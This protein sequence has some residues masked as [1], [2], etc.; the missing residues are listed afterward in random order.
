M[1]EEIEALARQKDF[2]ALSASERA[3]VLEAMPAEEYDRLHVLLQAVR[4]QHAHE[5]APAYLRASLIGRMAVNSRQDWFLRYVTPILRAAAIFILG[6]AT[7]MLLRKTTV[8]EKVVTE[9]THTV[10]TI[11]LEKTLWRERVRWKT[12]HVY[13]EKTPAKPSPAAVVN[14]VEHIALPEF[15]SKDLSNNAIGT[16]LGDTPELMQFFTQGGQ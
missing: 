12:K 8:V 9:H 13:I 14:T 11:Y 3:Q 15:N 5:D 7:A 2:A 10:D 16:S 1:N 4:M 6:M